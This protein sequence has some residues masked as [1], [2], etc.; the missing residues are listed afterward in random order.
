MNDSVSG[1][2][3]E[4]VS[5]DRGQRANLCESQIFKRD[6]IS[7]YSRIQMVVV[8]T[9]LPQPQQRSFNIVVDKTPAF[10]CFD[11]FLEG[12]GR[13]EMV[14]LTHVTNQGFTYCLT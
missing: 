11:V 14:R 4:H 12:L 8:V 3:S 6:P 2:P 1:F 5:L 7:C 10:E 13:S 9:M